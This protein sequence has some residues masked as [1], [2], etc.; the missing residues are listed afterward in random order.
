MEGRWLTTYLLFAYDGF[1]L[2]QIDFKLL[3]L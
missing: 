2:Q 3:K 1:E